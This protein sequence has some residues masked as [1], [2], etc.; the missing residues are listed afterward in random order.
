M[1][2][3][4]YGA[5]L[6]PTAPRQRG[7][8]AAG[9]S[10]VLE[11]GSPLSQVVDAWANELSRRELID[12]GGTALW[13]RGV[14]VV[15]P[16]EYAAGRATMRTRTPVVIKGSGRDARGER[17][18]RQAWLLPGE[19]EFDHYFVHNLRR[20]AQTLGLSS[21]VGLDLIKRVGPKRSFAVGGG[22]KPGAEIEAE[23]SGDP[24]LLQA[25]W[26]W[27]LGSANAAGFGWVAAAA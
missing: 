20:K 17:A 15:D 3:F 12:W 18:T 7:V 25:L 2:P 5:P 1:V 6:F 9:G 24:E 13:L 4:G 21:D 23:L 26:S 16:P 10:G 27:G 22:A 14:T 8:Y 11:F 19:P